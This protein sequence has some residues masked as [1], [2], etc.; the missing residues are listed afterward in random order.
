MVNSDHIT[1]IRQVLKQKNIDAAVI[2][3][4]VNVRYL[5]DFSGTSGAVVI[6]PR[7]TFFLTDYRYQDQARKQVSGYDIKIYRGFLDS[8]L[9]SL[10]KMLRSNVVGFEANALP[11]GCFKKLASSLKADLIPLDN[12]VEDLRLKKEKN[13]RSNQCQRAKRLNRGPVSRCW[14]IRARSR[15]GHEG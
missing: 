9:C 2:T 1:R 14:R 5:T 7:K 13:C 12:L 8:Y 6:S 10:I 15:K 3:K 11:Y 4:L